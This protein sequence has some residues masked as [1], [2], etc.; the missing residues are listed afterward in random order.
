[1]RITKEERFLGKIQ[2]VYVAARPPWSCFRARCCGCDSDV[3]NESMFR[4]KHFFIKGGDSWVYICRGC[5]PD[6]EAAVE[7]LANT[8]MKIQ[9]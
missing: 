5:A 8:W 9:P 6:K 2:D 7:V 4:I 3:Y 1:V